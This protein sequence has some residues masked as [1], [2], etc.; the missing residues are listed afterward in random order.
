MRSAWLEELPEVNS[1]MVEKC[2]TVLAFILIE[3]GRSKDAVSEKNK[4]ST[5]PLEGKSMHVSLEV[6]S[7]VM[8]AKGR[9]CY[10]LLSRKQKCFPHFFSSVFHSS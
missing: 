9:R 6:C 3:N 4:V 8:R 2:I 1:A 5:C 10:S 7:R